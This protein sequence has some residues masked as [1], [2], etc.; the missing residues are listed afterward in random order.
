MLGILTHT[1]LEEKR[2]GGE[3][4]QMGVQTTTNAMNKL[5]LLTGHRQV[6]NHTQGEKYNTG[7]YKKRAKGG[8]RDRRIDKK[9][10]KKPRKP[11]KMK[12]TILRKDKVIKEE[13][14]LR[15]TIMLKK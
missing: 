10:E 6:Q 2:E 11:T 14:E 5:E 4:E 3:R 9:Q 8:K 13:P 1:H 7:K 12:K 15:R